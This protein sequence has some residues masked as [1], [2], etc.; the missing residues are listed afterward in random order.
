[1]QPF[2]VAG[3][4]NREYTYSPAPSEVSSPA[5]DHSD[6]EVLLD[7]RRHRRLLVAETIEAAAPAVAYAVDAPLFDES[8]AVAQSLQ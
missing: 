7:P 5:S 4:T 2:S 8:D 3:S 6:D 1:M